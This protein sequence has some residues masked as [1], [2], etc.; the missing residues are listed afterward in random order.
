MVEESGSLLLKVGEFTVMY[1][2]VELFFGILDS[3]HNIESLM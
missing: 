1:A 2:V 3:G